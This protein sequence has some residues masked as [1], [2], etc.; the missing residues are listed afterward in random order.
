MSPPVKR[1]E[2]AGS[3]GADGGVPT[4]LGRY[5]NTLPEYD[6]QQED[7]ELSFPAKRRTN[8]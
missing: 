8:L 3:T 7:Y 5:Q 2:L 4:N 1:A 6:W